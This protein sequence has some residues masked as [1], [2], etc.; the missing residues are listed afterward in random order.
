MMV[1]RI[2]RSPQ[3]GHPAPGQLCVVRRMCDSKLE[4]VVGR[5]IRD[6]RLRHRPSSCGGR[7]GAAAGLEES[8]TVAHP[9]PDILWAAIG[10]PEEW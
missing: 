6:S 1:E 10:P 5:L 9:H 8:R 3:D 2:F 4:Y 7:M